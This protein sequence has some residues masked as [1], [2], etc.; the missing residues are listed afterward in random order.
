M[1]LIIDSSIFIAAE[2][3]VLDLTAKLPPETPVA[4]SAITVSELL[5]GVHRAKTTEQ[6]VKRQAFVGGLLARLPCIA[7]EAQVATIHAQLAAELASQGTTVGAH[8]LIIAATAI[9]VGYEVATRD[10]RS[11]PR[12]PGL[13]VV[14]W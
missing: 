8:D 14:H 2:R 11:F 4:I 3:G 10:L 9:S 5:H 12:V 13:N 1:G 6:K 7:F